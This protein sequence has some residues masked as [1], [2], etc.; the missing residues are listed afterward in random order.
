MELFILLVGALLLVYLI[1]KRI[2]EKKKEN[3]E[4]RDH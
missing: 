1:Y 4:D 2:E 3:F